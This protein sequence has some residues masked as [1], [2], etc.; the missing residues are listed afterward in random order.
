M[1]H[2][3]MMMPILLDVTEPLFYRGY[4]TDPITATQIINFSTNPILQQYNEK[5]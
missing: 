4:N 1:H 2:S 5:L 3:D